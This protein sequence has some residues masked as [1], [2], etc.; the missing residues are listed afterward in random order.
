[1]ESTIESGHKGESLHNVGKGEEFHILWHFGL[2]L[3]PNCP[4]EDGSV[5][6]NRTDYDC[7]SFVVRTAAAT[8][9]SD[10]DARVQSSSITR[11]REVGHIFSVGVYRPFIFHCHLA[12]GPFE[13]NHP[14]TRS[15]TDRTTTLPLCERP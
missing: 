15:S 1:M 11:S 6:V 4:T 10:C 8:W 2:G 9:C 3:A 7:D 14:A 12:T 5:G 13:T